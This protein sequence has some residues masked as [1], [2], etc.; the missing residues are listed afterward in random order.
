MS[1]TVSDTTSGPLKLPNAE[2]AVKVPKAEKVAKAPK[3]EKVPKAEKAEKISKKKNTTASTDTNT[4]PVTESDTVSSAKVSD[5][6][7]SVETLANVSVSITSPCC[8]VDSLHPLKSSEKKHDFS[9]ITD[10]R[11]LHYRTML[12]S[13]Y[14]LV[15]YFGTLMWEH[16]RNYKRRFPDGFWAVDDP[17]LDALIDEILKS[18]VAPEYRNNNT[19]SFVIGKLITIAFNGYDFVENEYNKYAKARELDDLELI[20]NGGVKKS[21]TNDELAEDNKKHIEYRRACVRHLFTSKVLSVAEQYALDKI[22]AEVDIFMDEQAS[23]EKYDGSH[24]IMGGVSDADW[25]LDNK[26]K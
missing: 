14:D 22:N 9:Y 26:N 10:K 25:H 6:P 12:N 18:D 13:G 5:K 1:E 17:L 4:A 2:K 21:K 8:E 15:D 11:D 7:E 24:K 16:L 19:C 20:A 23:N 3:A